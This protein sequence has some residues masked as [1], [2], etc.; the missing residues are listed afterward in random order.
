MPLVPADVIISITG[1]PGTG[2]SSAGSV[3]ASR[4]RRVIEL[5]DL[6]KEQRLY[7]GMDEER[8]SLEVDTDALAERLPALLPDGDVILIGHLSHLV[9]TD[10]IVV[11]RC[12][13]S[14]LEKRLEGRGWPEAKVREN[15]EAEALDVILVESIESGTD[16]AE[17]DTTL[18]TPSQVADAVEEI[19]AGEREK[20][21][22][23]NVDWSQEVLGWY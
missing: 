10:L 4:G 19:L 16:A 22:V 6:I 11:L 21:T 8:G 13:P 15:M 14:V 20:Y 9:P 17:V 7:D 12:R 2:K 5:G 3:L 1:T 18:M 23:G